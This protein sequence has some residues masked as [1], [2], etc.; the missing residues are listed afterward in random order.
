MSDGEKQIRFGG[1]AVDMELG[2]IVAGDGARTELRPKTAALLRALAARP[3]AL[4]SKDELVAEVWEGLAVDDDGIVQCVG[5]IRRALGPAGREALRT[6]PRRG[7]S[8]HPDAAPANEPARPAESASQTATVSAP[9]PRGRALAT[10]ATIATA[11]LIALGAVVWRDAAPAPDQSAPLASVYGEGVVLTVPPFETATSDA[12]LASLAEGMALQVAGALV[13]TRLITVVDESE[14][15]PR[16]D[17]GLE[18]GKTGVAL[19]GRFI[20]KGVLR[21]VGDRVQ[22]TVWLVDAASG[23]KLWSQAYDHARGDVGEFR[24]DLG[25]HIAAAAFDEV[26]DAAREAAARKPEAERRAFDFVLLANERRWLWTPEGNADAIA[27]VRKAL[28]L[29]P[30]S[31]VAWSELAR[32]YAQ[33]VWA[34]FAAS[35]EEASV[36]WREAAMQAVAADGNYPFARA[37]LADYYVYARSWDDALAEIDQALAL[38]PWLPELLA[39]AA[40]YVLPWVGQ[41]A[42]AADL[43]DRAKR[44]DPLAYFKDAEAAAYFFASRFPEATAAIAAMGPEPSRQIRLLATLSYAQLG[45]AAAVKRWRERFRRSWPDYDVEAIEETYFAPQAR[46]ERALWRESH[47]R[48]GL[49]PCAAAEG[50]AGSAA[51]PSAGCEEARASP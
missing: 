38:A 33:Q 50:Q 8:L 28:A 2:A 26:R 43:L 7:Y 13:A 11:L 46:A 18:A 19:G 25:D 36:L 16:S 41:S 4:V 51:E 23:A 47:Q 10:G 35:E 14:A 29:E 12:V 49:L 20:L 32:L 48:A 42:R 31:A 9:R 27:L 3:G 1:S 17:A 45:D 21:L 22:A 40:E 30:R 34:G 24:D 6:H 44:L 15:P 5:E 37:A 39:F